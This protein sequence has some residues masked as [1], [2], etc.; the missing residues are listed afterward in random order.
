MISRRL[1]LWMG[2]DKKG[3]DRLTWFCEYSVKQKCFHVE[4]EADCVNSNFRMLERG[5]ECSF[6]PVGSFA[7]REEAVEFS[8]KLREEMP[9]VFR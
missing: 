2:G 3:G 9:E 1:L 7:T 5:I 6:I 8:E 4:T